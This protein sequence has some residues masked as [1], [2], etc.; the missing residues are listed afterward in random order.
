MVEIK[1]LLDKFDDLD[2]KTKRLRTLLESLVLQLGC[3]WLLDQPG[4]GPLRVATLIDA[5]FLESRHRNGFARLAGIAPQ[6]DSSGER[7]RF[8]NASIRH[9]ALFSTLMDWAHWSAM[10]RSN[11]PRAR[12]YYLRK[13]SEGKTRCTA[14]RCLARQLINR[15]FKLRS[16]H[17]LSSQTYSE[18]RTPRAA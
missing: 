3:T 7:T 2:A 1:E 4:L 8:V 11:V 17:R 15:L 16:E 10:P 12:D 6:E 13:R 5:G 18:E 9:K 14:L